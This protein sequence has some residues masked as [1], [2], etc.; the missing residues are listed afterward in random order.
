MC[1]VRTRLFKKWYL[2]L[3]YLAICSCNKMDYADTVFI[4]GKI[5]TVDSNFS[6]AEAISIK[7]NL[8]QKVGSTSEIM[9]LVGS[10]T[11]TIDLDGKMVLPGFYEGHVHPVNA[12]QKNTYY[13][14]PTIQSLSDLFRWIQTETELKKEGEWIVHPKFFATR[15]LELRQP[16]LRELD[17]LSPN[18]PVF[19][20]GS[21]GGMINSMAMKLSGIGQ[22]TLHEGVLKR[23]V[24]GKPTGLIR[25]SA[26]E[27]LSKSS[28]TDSMTEKDEL[29]ALQSLLKLYNQVGITSIC[30]GSGNTKYL[31][32]FR[33]LR[34]RGKLTV[35]VFQNISAPFDVHASEDIIRESLRDLGYATGEGD[36]WVRV[37]ALKV[38]VDGGILTGTAYLS[39][40][41][42]LDAMDIYGI[43]D[44]NYRGIL[45][46]SRD[47]LTRIIKI[48]SEFG[49]KFTAHVTG[50][51]GVDELLMAYAEVNKIYSTKEQ[52]HSIIHGNFFDIAAIKKMSELGI[53]GDVQPAW[54]YK[55]AYLMNRVLGGE[56]MK[57]FHPYS[58]MVNSNIILNGGSDH[59]IKSDS[60]TSINPFNPFLTLSVLINR[61]TENGKV[62]NMDERVSREEGIKMLTINNAMASFEEGIKGSL[63]EGKLADL[64]VLSN[65][66]LTCETDKIKNIKVELTMLDG[67]IIHTSE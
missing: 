56:R 24:D 18:H 3:V 64:I 12:S 11:H 60:Y 57:T 23:S 48:A 42:G 34:E 13:D 44:P 52:R 33:T 15:V 20:N 10:N 43:A 26:F 16:T 9:K 29:D 31:N 38:I 40:P 49:W 54:Y 51:G 19:L 25:S 53:Y 50:G 58:S 7:E 65:D 6:I 36:E 30:S 61:I 59:M 4:N 41:W 21:Y 55:D 47:E 27:L 8:I 46:I 22:N 45:N 32:L 14:L 67:N 37:G 66:I 2:F 28:N 39:E 63:E 1:F 62:F 17:S 35:R 5:V